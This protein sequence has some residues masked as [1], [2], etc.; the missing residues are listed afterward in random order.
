VHKPENKNIVNCRWVFSTKHDKFGNLVKYKSRLVARGFTQEYMTDFDETF[1]F[2]V[3]NFYC[4]FQIN[5]I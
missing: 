3:L 5:T 4:H 1:A 2:P